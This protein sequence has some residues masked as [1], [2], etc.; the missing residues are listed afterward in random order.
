MAALVGLAMGCGAS[1]V[2][3]DETVAVELDALFATRLDRSTATGCNSAHCHAGVARPNFS[4]ADDFYRATVNQ[5]SSLG[6]GTYVR[7]FDLEGSWL[8][9]KLLPDANP[10]MPSGGPYFDEGA[11]REVAGWIC[12]GAPGPATSV[13]DGGH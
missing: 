9:R 7:P 10:R 11:L 6:N 8:Y 4:N 13:A 2:H 5:T 12:A 1:A 3:C